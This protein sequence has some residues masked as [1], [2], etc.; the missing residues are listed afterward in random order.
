MVPNHTQSWVMGLHP[1]ADAKGSLG[2]VPMVIRCYVSLSK[3]ISLLNNHLSLFP[4]LLQ[5]HL[6]LHYC[7]HHPR[8]RPCALRI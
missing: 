2:Y 8:H 1:G 5:L 3:S 7:L 6:H 4:P